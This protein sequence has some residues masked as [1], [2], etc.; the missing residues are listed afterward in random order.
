MKN[1]SCLFVGGGEHFHF[2][3]CGGYMDACCWMEILR[4][5]VKSSDLRS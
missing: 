5:D 3:E 2:Y 4:G 1:E